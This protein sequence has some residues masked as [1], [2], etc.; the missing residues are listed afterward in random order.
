MCSIALLTK[1]YIKEEQKLNM[2]MLGLMLLK[3]YSFRYEKTKTWMAI[4]T[5]FAR[6]LKVLTT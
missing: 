2:Q 3:L 5:V 1:N 6:K 4:I